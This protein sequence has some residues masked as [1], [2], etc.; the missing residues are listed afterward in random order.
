MWPAKPSVMAVSSWSEF[1]GSAQNLGGAI[2]VNPW[3]LDEMASA[4]LR[5][6]MMSENERRDR[7][8]RMG[9]YVRKNTR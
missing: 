1:A 6:V 2:I 5:A 4:M 8:Y 9:G 7:W 3:N